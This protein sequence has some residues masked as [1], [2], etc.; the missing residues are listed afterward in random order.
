MKM[1]MFIPLFGSIL[2]VFTFLFVTYWV[3]LG[4]NQNIGNEKKL[5][6]QLILLG[7]F[8]AGTVIIALALPVSESTRNQII[9]LIGVLVSGIIVLSSTNITANIMAGIMLRTTKPFRIGDF[10]W[11]DNN[12]GRVT[13]RGTICSNY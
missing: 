1:S 7:I 8:V 9:A 3:L 12:F 4:R 11:V 6:R 10:V 13:E 2:G 5:P